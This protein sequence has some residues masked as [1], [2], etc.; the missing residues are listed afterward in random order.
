MTV[1]RVKISIAEYSMNRP[2]TR[3][4]SSPSTKLRCRVSLKPFDRT[5]RSLPLRPQRPRRRECPPPARHPHPRRLHSQ[6]SS[7]L[8]SPFREQ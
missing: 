6:A 3:N 8:P 4:S 7:S 1:N 2:L 5:H